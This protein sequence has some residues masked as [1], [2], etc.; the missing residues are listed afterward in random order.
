MVNEVERRGAAEA[1]DGA[2]ALEP[3]VRTIIAVLPDRW[4]VL[5]AHT[6]C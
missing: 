2:V 6:P 3:S 4:D 5:R 1:L